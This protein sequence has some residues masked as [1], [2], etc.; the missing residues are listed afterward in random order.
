MLSGHLQGLFLQMLS[1][2]VRP[3]YILELGTYTGYSAICLAK[4][5]QQGGK[6]HTVDRDK[7]LQPVRDQYWQEAGLQGVIEQ[8]IGDAATV[9]KGLEPPFDL[10]F[11]DADKKN[12]GLYFDL[13]IDKMQPGAYFLADN[14]LYS[15]EVV[16]PQ[17][18]RSNNARVIHEFNKKI[19]ADERVEQ[20][21]LPI[22]DGV[23]IIRKK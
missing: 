22:R 7:S 15:G 19:A 5:L 12:Y 18:Q 1:L 14:V 17:E 13:L 21:I 2:M 10:V 6:L 23:M 11:I 8:H 4:G 3:K 9:I 16:L 20:V